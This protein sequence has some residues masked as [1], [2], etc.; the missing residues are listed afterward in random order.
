MANTDPSG[1]GG[2]ETVVYVSDVEDAPLACADEMRQAITEDPTRRVLI[3]S[4]T[5]S[6]DVIEEEWDTYIG[7]DVNP[8]SVALII[9]SPTPN[10]VENISTSSASGTP[11]NLIYT[12]PHDLTGITISMSK[13]LE[14][15]GDAEIAV[16]LRDLDVLTRYHE[17]DRVFRFVTSLVQS[18]REA[19]TQTHA[20]IR[21]DL[22][23]EKDANALV[24]LFDRVEG[25]RD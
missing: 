7:E 5:E 18:L 24:A 2:N 14:S 20:H 3:F 21:P 12:N 16:C 19:D 17:P 1:S 25:E 13:V 10:T 15:W 23:D 11:V 22:L 8:D 4:V 6:P 9:A